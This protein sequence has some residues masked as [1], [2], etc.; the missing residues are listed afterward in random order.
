MAITRTDLALESMENLK[1]E[2]KF[3]SLHGVAVKESRRQGFPV[4][5]IHITDPHSGK[6]IGKPV[7][8]YA[9]IDLR[10]Y[11]RR[12]EGFFP[13]ACRCIAHE[14]AAL[15]PADLRPARSGCP[16]RHTG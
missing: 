5:A 6:A 15:L 4:T 1:N 12:E 3:S 10:P 11:F 13:R 14:V 8:H 7:G 2:K 16:V 9:T